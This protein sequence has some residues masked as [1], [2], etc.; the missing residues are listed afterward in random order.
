MTSAKIYELNPKLVES[1]G[2]IDNLLK[3]LQENQNSSVVSNTLLC[4]VEIEKMKGEKIL[5]PSY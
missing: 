3:V 1:S 2:M 5:I 4:I